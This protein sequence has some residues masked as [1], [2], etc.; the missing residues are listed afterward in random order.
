MRHNYI[1]GY[2]VAELPCCEVGEFNG[3]TIGRNLREYD[4]ATDGD[5]ELYCVNCVFAESELN[6]TDEAKLDIGFPIFS[7]D[8]NEK[9]LQKYGPYVK[10]PI[11]EYS[12]HGDGTKLQGDGIRIGL[13]V[14]I[15]NDASFAWVCERTELMNIPTSLMRNI[16]DVMNGKKNFY[17][18]VVS[19][20]FT[21]VLF[22][23]ETRGFE[24]DD[25]MPVEASN[26]LGEDIGDMIAAMSDNAKG[27][28]LAVITCPVN[29][30]LHGPDI[31]A[32]E[33]ID[34]RHQAEELL[35]CILD[36]VCDAVDPELDDK[37]FIK[38][39]KG[40]TVYSFEK[41][42]YLAIIA[43]YDLFKSRIWD[44]IDTHL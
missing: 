3:A 13:G 28:T 15:L 9:Y 42:H 23:T 31:G 44:E 5:K 2:N 14:F 33:N 24:R 35:D 30:L 8:E 26:Y 25:E 20:G 10:H 39:I 1:S 17:Q 29:F 18:K 43:A 4:E 21:N 22:V 12:E 41:E 7:K 11:S 38:I 27:N 34:A 32:N 37:A 19:K 6:G 16:R 36:P 40:E